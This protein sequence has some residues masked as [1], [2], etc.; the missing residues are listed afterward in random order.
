MVVGGI[1][2][3]MDLSSRINTYSTYIHTYMGLGS[4]TGDS[5]LRLHNDDVMEK[6][7]ASTPLLSMLVLMAVDCRLRLFLQGASLWGVRTTAETG[8]NM[9]TRSVYYTKFYTTYVGI[10]ELVLSMYVHMYTSIINLKIT[11]N[12]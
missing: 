11:A 9:G 3:R 6:T 12:S 7:D 1:N 5:L 8:T 2:S 4:T 10:V